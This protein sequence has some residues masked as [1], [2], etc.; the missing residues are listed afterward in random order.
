MSEN[1]L[2]TR[3]IQLVCPRSSNSDE[4]N[5]QWQPKSVLSE[6]EQRT[7]TRKRGRDPVL[8]SLT[9]VLKKR[10]ATKKQRTCPPVTAS[11]QTP[12]PSH[13]FRYGMARKK[14]KPQVLPT[15]VM[16]RQQMREDAFREVRLESFALAGFCGLISLLCH[17]S[18]VLGIVGLGRVPHSI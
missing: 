17:S 11:N 8:S 2:S 12:K 18:L 10:Q 5:Q 14:T 13:H 1:T 6:K 4:E 3:N 16:L 15:A 7:K 9:S